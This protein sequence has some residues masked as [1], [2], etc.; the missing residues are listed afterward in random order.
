MTIFHRPLLGNIAR[1]ATLSLLL[2][3]M[4]G[5]SLHLRADRVSIPF[6]CEARGVELHARC[7]P[8][9]VYKSATPEQ[10]EEIGREVCSICDSF[11]RTQ[12]L[13]RRNSVD[14][15]LPAPARQGWKQT[16]DAYDQPLQHCRAFKAMIGSCPQSP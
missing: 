10:R 7:D 3:A 6:F 8:L 14:P 11:Q 1:L 2:T 4:T 12:D 5:C 15:S 9:G 13:A 16:A